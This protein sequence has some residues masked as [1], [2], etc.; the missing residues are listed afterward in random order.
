MEFLTFF[1]AG[2]L[3]GSA[4]WF[5]VSFVALAIL[6]T[7]SEWKESG[8]IAAVGFAAFI[9]VHWHQ[10]TTTLS[11]IFTWQNI[12][13]Y[14]GIG[15]VYALIRSFFSARKKRAEY[16]SLLERDSELEKNSKGQNKY[17][18]NAEDQ[19]QRWL[20]D[21][22]MDAIRWISIWPISIPLWFLQD[23][24][25]EIFSWLYDKMAIVFRK[26]FEAGLK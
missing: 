19:L 14:I 10:G 15:I 8:V 7:I 20:D 23:M 2:A 4:T 26:V 1:A 13:I 22:K 12:L 25:A 24:L 5:W 16:Q 9:G 18:N 21:L 11:Q 17:N 6:F 3:F